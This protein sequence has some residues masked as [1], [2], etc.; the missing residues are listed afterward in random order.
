MDSAA[1]ALSLVD[2]DPK[3]IMPQRDITGQL[4]GDG[5]GTLGSPLPPPRSAPPPPVRG[6]EQ[7]PPTRNT[8]VR[9][10][11]KPPVAAPDPTPT[12]T[13]VDS[14][15][16]GERESARAA[17][18]EVPTLSAAESAVRI[19]GAISDAVGVLG[20]R[21]GAAR[22][23]RGDARDAWLALA[24]E[25]R[26]SASVNGDADVTVNGNEATATTPLTVTVRSPFGANR[27]QSARAQ[28]ELSLRSGTWYV[29]SVRL[30]DAVTLR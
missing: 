15:T 5:S 2:P 3:A 11:S 22:L 16:K 19:R 6:G 10:P 9:P 14:A 12:P 8:P 23:L 29:T 4:I 21:D 18:R 7:A 1:A 30:L 28:A 26:V 13:P 27:R 17:S 20:T 25:Q 24:S